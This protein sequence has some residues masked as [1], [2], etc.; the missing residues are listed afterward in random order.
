VFKSIKITFCIIILSLGL[1]SLTNIISVKANPN[2]GTPAACKSAI[3]KKDIKIWDLPNISAFLPIIPAACALDGENVQPLG[4][5]ALPDILIRV[6]GFMFSFAFYIL[7]FAFVLLGFNL[8]LKPFDPS[9]N[10][11]QFQEITTLGRL[12]AKQIG[13]IVFG[14]IIIVFAYTVVFTILRLFNFSSDYTNLDKF[15]EP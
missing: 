6:V 11:N 10:K 9:I 4:V 7:P 3:A 12:I 8:A 2:L 1:F 13:Q 14:I 5:T 15:F